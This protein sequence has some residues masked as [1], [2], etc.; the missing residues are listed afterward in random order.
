MAGGIWVSARPQAKAAA[1]GDRCVCMASAPA[2]STPPSAAGFA[3]IEVVV[4]GLIAVIVTGGVIGLINSTG[5]AG[6]EERHRSQAFSIA[7]EDQARLRSTQIAGPG[8]R[9]NRRR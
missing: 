2:R 3:L 4:S 5:R 8:T 7:Q 9:C 6:A 1:S